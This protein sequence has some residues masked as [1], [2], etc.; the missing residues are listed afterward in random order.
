M[1]SNTHKRA[2]LALIIANIIWG[3]AAPIFKLALTNI[4][5]FTLAFIRFGGAA[6]LLFPFVTNNWKIAKKDWINLIMLSFCGIT[7]NI[8]FFFLGLENTPSVNA[9][10][11]ASAGPIFLY[12]LSIVFLHEKP[13][14]RVI[15]GMVISLLGVMIVIGQPILQG[16]F[17]GQILGNIYLVL[18]TFG[19]VGHA[20]F[21]KKILDKYNSM[22]V[23]FWSF[24]I[25]AISFIPLFYYEMINSD[26]FSK[27]G[28]SGWFGVYFGIFLSSA[29]AYILYEWGIKRTDVQEVGLFTYIDPVIAAIIAIPLLGES[30]TPVLILG[31]IFIFSGIYI[32]EGRINYH[33]IHK[34]SE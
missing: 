29:L 30:I 12:L 20:I 25:G 2:V 13:H 24:I 18:A 26:P 32:A 19:A 31:A 5:P 1:R 3:A 34:L 10:V 23:T 21:S 9:P 4:T 17:D 11:I 27:I 7:I 14:R 16:E 15:S 28:L 8:T 33:P 22:V 6:L